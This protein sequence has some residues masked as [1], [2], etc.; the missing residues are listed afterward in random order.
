MRTTNPK[1]IKIKF[2]QN[3]TDTLRLLKTCYSR[4][5]K[6]GLQCDRKAHK[7]EEG[8]SFL[9]KY[10]KNNDV[11]VGHPPPNGK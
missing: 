7:I 4:L 3:I 11:I 6:T 10:Y 8:G 9:C 2:S 1:L 5:Q